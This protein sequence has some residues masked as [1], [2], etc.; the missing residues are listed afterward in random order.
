MKNS[1]KLFIAIGIIVVVI[2]VIF[3]GLKN[4]RVNTQ[5]KMILFYGNTCPHCKIVE[6]YI[7]DNNVR[8]HFK[9]QQLEV[10][11]NQQ[12]ALLLGRYA[13]KCGIDSAQGVGVPFFWTGKECLIGQTEVINFF[14]DK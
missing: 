10:F 1:N 11:D 8:A 13:H 4:R 7:S 5:P 3:I 6:Q 9:F 2:A 12:N 14:K